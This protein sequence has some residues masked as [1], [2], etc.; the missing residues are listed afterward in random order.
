MPY[1]NGLVVFPTFF[2]LTL[3]FQFYDLSHS[4]LLAF[5]LLLLLLLSV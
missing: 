4:Q 2:N 5:L 1:M 3:N